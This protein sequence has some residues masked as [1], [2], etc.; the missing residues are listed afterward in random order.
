LHAVEQDIIMRQ[1]EIS[2]LKKQVNLI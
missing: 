2:H 1:A